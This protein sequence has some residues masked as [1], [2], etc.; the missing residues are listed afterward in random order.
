MTASVRGSTLPAAR[1]TRRVRWGMSGGWLDDDRPVDVDDEQL[2]EPVEDDH[3]TWR[4]TDR[5]LEERPPH[6]E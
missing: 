6:W 3:E 5:L 2:P 4:P 1:G